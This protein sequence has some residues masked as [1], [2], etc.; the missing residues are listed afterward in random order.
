MSQAEVV[1]A[2]SSNVKMEPV[3]SS[4]GNV[5]VT[6]TVV[7]VVMN[8][9]FVVRVSERVGEAFQNIIVSTTN[10]LP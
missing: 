6:L 1:I 8:P 4:H 3:Y 10:V 9:H 7:M 2:F 5:T